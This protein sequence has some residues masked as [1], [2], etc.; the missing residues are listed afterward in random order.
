MIVVKVNGEKYTIKKD[1]SV[2]DG[3]AREFIEHCI[4]MV[5]S[6]YSV[7]M[8][9]FEPYLYIKLAAFKAIELV[10]IDF[11]APEDENAVY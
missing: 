6:D 8:G 7:W 3:S 11:E 2:S 4:E 1:F 5:R 10:S 9:F